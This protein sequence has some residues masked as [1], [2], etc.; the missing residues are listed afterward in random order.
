[1]NL[2]VT[3][4][5]DET[6]LE[7]LRPEWDALLERSRTATIFS[8]FEWNYTAW[9]YHRSA[10]RP[11]VLRVADGP[12]LVALMPLR[13]LSAR[14]R[15]VLQ[16]MGMGYSSLADYL[17]I[18]AADGYE[19]AAV[20]A[21][22]RFLSRSKM[23]WSVLDWPELS[24]D[25]PSFAVVAQEAA[26]AGLH[27]LVTPGTACWRIPLPATVPEYLARLSPKMRRA[28]SHA[29]R[30]QRETDARF[31]LV[32]AEGELDDA[33]RALQRLQEHRWGAEGSVELSAYMGFVGAVLHAVF[34]RGWLDLSML[35]VDG[36]AVAITCAF[37][38][39]S[40]VFGFVSGFDQDPRW[41]KYGVGI[42]NLVAS[43]KR[44]IDDGYRTFDLSRGDEW[45]KSR[46]A[47]EA[48][49][50]YRVRVVRSR[51]RL[52]ALQGREALKAV[53]SRLPAGARHARHG[54]H[55]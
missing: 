49:R 35:R 3:V 10:A 23:R 11:F 19:T 36:H 9:A 46:L 31:E 7:A 40:T 24:G 50:N 33:I 17:D 4:V 15:V 48:S 16:P 51:P 14:G 27:C 6:V 26:A 53:R 8:T 25:S 2:Q 1:M 47:G 42:L 34:R 13:V 38:F 20:E 22:L 28:E 52:W 41:A 43:I 12:V 29:R 32:G 54:S 21:V 44:A 37:R 45:Y 39:R 55:E 5:E 30:L 18:L